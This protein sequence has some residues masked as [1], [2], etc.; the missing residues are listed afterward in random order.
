MAVEFQ[1][2]LIPWPSRACGNTTQLQ[3]NAVCCSWQTGVTHTA[4]A[5]HGRA[6]GNRAG[7]GSVTCSLGAGN[8]FAHVTS[9][10]T[11]FPTGARAC[12]Q[13]TCCVV[14]TG[15][16]M[17]SMS[18]SVL[19]PVEVTVTLAA[20]AGAPPWNDSLAVLVICSREPGSFTVCAGYFPALLCRGS[21]VG[22][23]VQMPLAGQCQDLFFSLKT[24]CMS[25]MQAAWG[26][27]LDGNTSAL[28]AGYQKCQAN[29]RQHV[30]W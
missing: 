2:S 6:C 15:S 24:L 19:Q 29:N 26:S 21:T 16:T 18:G 23:S 17:N 30:G 4:S 13:V 25:S 22:N 3:D 5:G 9:H 20:D 12:F 11:W 28:H 7:A 1:H 10:L 8:A 14:M 27:A